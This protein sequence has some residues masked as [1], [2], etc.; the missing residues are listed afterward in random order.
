MGSIGQ[1]YIRDYFNPNLMVSELWPKSL[2]Y[3]VFGIN[4]VFTIT[5]VIL[6]LL[7]AM[8]RTCLIITI[9]LSGFLAQSCSNKSN[10]ETSDL[11]TISI[12]DFRDYLMD[13]NLQPCLIERICLINVNK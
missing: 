1:K 12:H 6:N 4:I 7:F 11:L 8:I 2:V 3:E 9:L 13:E 5:P 10:T